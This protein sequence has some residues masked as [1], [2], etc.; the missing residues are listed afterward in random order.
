MINFIYQYEA[1]NEELNRED[2][3][4]LN[5]ECRNPIGKNEF[6]PFY[7]YIYK[8]NKK[9]QLKLE[10]YLINPFLTEGEYEEHRIK[11]LNQYMSIGEDEYVHHNQYLPQQRIHI[12]IH[13]VEYCRVSGFIGKPKN[14]TG[15]ASGY[16]GGHSHDKGY[17]SGYGGGHSHDKGY[18]SGY[19]GGHSH[20]K[21]YGSGYGGYG[22][23]G[24]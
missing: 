1:I 19:G 7:L 12:T 2:C 21:G 15:S 10:K 24:N 22:Y 11:M 18:G 20:D 4:K 6:N 16:G 14:D 17:G 9:L 8:L 13:M 5:N 3:I 23:Y